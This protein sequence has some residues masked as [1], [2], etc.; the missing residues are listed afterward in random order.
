M[1]S[2]P[3]FRG[4]SRSAALD[5]TDPLTF[6]VYEPDR[7]VLGKRMEDH[8]RIAVCL[9]H[10]FNW[11]G[12]DVFGVGTFDRPWLDPGIDP[13]AAAHRQARRR[14]RVHREAR[15][16]VLLLPRSRRR[17]RGPDV[18]RDAGEPRHDPRPDR[19]PHGP[20]RGAA[21]VG[22]GQPVQPS[23]LRRRRGHEP[24]SGGVRLRGGAGEA[25]ARGARSGSTARTTCCGAAAR[26]TRRC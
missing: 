13:M 8:L 24:G 16:A 11:P 12:S 18:R 9:W 10:S 5:S 14:V 2:S 22:H 20:D 26:A 19:G 17:A 25:D 21:P 23:P 7:L 6:K 4:R 1:T 3:T 15:R